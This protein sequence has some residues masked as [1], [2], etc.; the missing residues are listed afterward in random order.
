MRELVSGPRQSGR[1]TTLIMTMIEEMEMHDQQIYLVS[2]NHSHGQL[3]KDMVR[4]LNGTVSRIRI[5]ALESLYTLGGVDPRNIYIEHM[6][7]ERANS[8]QLRN[9][10][11]IEDSKDAMIWKI[12]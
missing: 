10:Y 9:L 1:T 5:V 12:A 8:T 6:A 11:D 2:Y 4:T 3:L 7:Y